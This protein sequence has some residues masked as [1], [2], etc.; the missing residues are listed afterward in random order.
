MDI[1]QLKYFLEVASSEHV[2][3]SAKRLHVAQP[4]LTQSIHRLE[5]ELGVKL[6][7]R[8]G[9]NIRLTKTGAYL[10]DRVAPAMASL[11]TLRED[12]RAFDDEQKRSVR[13]GIFS[14]SGLAVDGITAYTAMHADVSFQITQDQLERT[15]DVTVTTVARAAAGPSVR[16]NVGP[17][18]RATTADCALFSEKIG[19]AVPKDSPYGSQV[20]LAELSGER[21]I[22]LAGSRRFREICDALCARRSFFP[23]IGF[24]SDNPAVVKKIIGLGLG[25]GFWPARSWESLEGSNAR[26]VMLDEDEFERCVIITRGAHVEEGSEADR[27]FRFLTDYT[28]KR[29]EGRASGEAKRWES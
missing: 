28:A 15:C 17:D 6:F 26:L 23:H 3:N 8:C 2:T 19:V 5:D 1:L 29:W 14:A 7:E 18:V 21:F 16:S 22:C 27:F 12:V 20:S 24:E 13:V 10:R 4:A 9:R 11:D 25:V